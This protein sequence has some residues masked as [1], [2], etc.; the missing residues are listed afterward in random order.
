MASRKNVSKWL[1]LSMSTCLMS[2]AAQRPSAYVRV[3]QVGYEAAHA[4]FRAY[5]MSTVAE[6]GASF[7]VLNANGRDVYGAKVGSL[8]GIWS[9]SENLA[10]HVYAL[11]FTVPQPGKYKI[12]VSGQSAATSPSFPVD[13]PAALYSGLLLNTKFFYETERDGPEYVPNALRSAPGH[14]N[15]QKAAVYRTPPLDDNDLIATTGKPLSPTG[16]AIDASGGWWD[17]GDY[18]KYVETISYTVALQE[19]GIR[20]FPGQM[21][22]DAPRNPPAPPDAISYA[23]DTAGAPTSSDFTSEAKFGIRFLMKMWDDESRTLYYQVGNSQD[24]VNFPDLLSDY[25]IWRLPQADDTWDGCSAGAKYICHRPVF[26]AG[27]ARSKISPNL[28]GR[29]AAD[30]A[31]C[32]QLN[33]ASD[34]ALAN[35]CLKDAEDIFELADTSFADPAASVGSGTCT[36][37]CL[38]TIIPFDGYPE[39]VWDD[40]MELGATELYLALRSAESESNLPP[41]LCQTNARYYLTQAARFARNYITRIYETGNSDTLNLYDV[42]GL[43][44]F[45]LYRALQAAGNP[46]DL[47]VTQSSIRGQLL[48]QVG[49]AIKQAGTDAWGFGAA[50]N[51]DTASHGDGLSVMASEAYY[52]TD[53]RIYDAYSQRWMANVFGAN[54][55]GSSFI[56]GDGTKTFPNCIQHQVANLAGALDG[57]SGGIPVLWGAVSEGPSGFAT[58]GVV[59]GMILC[60]A[61]GA[62]PFKIFN[63]NDGA[64]NPSQISVYEDNMQSYTTTEPAIDLTASSF[65]MWSWRLA[66]HP[67]SE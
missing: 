56:V 11:D 3:S 8:L 16:A 13:T 15:D 33:H 64:F 60:P 48:R 27:P 1:I 21:G 57:T 28:A 5:L 34:P 17:A 20:D 38:L 29:L 37:G 55:W 2:L 65:L 39:N 35:R 6:S 14:L 51:S 26:V 52:L 59:S 7:R 36:S 47:A 54:A 62:D 30:F 49:D 61:N 45:E 19:I 43:A 10:Y 66:G 42:S 25:D 9:N 18:M 41:G 50:W 63:G 4:P 24:W 46:K 40:D 23:G 58:S 12:S 67:S 31:V 44:H 53:S 32:Y 22:P